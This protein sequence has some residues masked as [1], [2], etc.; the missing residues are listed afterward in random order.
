[1]RIGW[2]LFI[3]A[4]LVF[5]IAFGGEAFRVVGESIAL[6]ARE[7]PR[8]DHPW[9][10]AHLCARG[11][12]QL[13]HCVTHHPLFLRVELVDGVVVAHVGHELVPLGRQAGGL[14]ERAGADQAFEDA[15]ADDARIDA[16]AEIGEAG[17]GALLAFGD[18]VLHRRVADALG[19]LPLLGA[20]S[21]TL[22]RF[23]VLI[24]MATR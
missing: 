17:K 20:L 16:L 12:H 2:G 5:A 7:H 6:N 9:N 23:L 8:E 11:R 18:D 4:Y 15:L 10:P 24:V 19:R 3:V 14:V 22:R 21:E 1:M 13:A